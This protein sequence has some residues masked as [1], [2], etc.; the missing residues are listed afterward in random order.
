MILIWPFCWLWKHQ[1]SLKH[2]KSLTGY[3]SLLHKL[4]KCS[5]NGCPVLLSYTVRPSCRCGWYSYFAQYVLCWNPANIFLPRPLK[6]LWWPMRMHESHFIVTMLLRLWPYRSD[7]PQ[8]VIQTRNIAA[9]CETDCCLHW[10]FTATF[11]AANKVSFWPRYS[12]YHQFVGTWNK[13]MIVSSLGLSLHSEIFGSALCH[14]QVCSP[15]WPR[16]I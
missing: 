10:C 9:T 6:S 15:Y 12:A 8:A 16:W 1:I 14:V 13:W 7:P 4:Q 2:S 11:T 5:F 3:S